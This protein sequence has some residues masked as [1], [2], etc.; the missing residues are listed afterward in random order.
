MT[1]AFTVLTFS[2]AVRA[3]QTRYGTREFCAA[4]EQKMPANGVLNEAA[5]AFIS[6]C[7]SFLIGTANREGWPYVQHRGGPKGFLRILDPDTLAFADY[8][9]NKQYITVGNLSENDK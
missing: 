4:L 9:G 8:S 7:D 6:N 5:T 1:R 3:A 2:D